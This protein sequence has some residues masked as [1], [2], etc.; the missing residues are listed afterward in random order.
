MSCFEP[1]GIPAL[2]RFCG[3]MTEFVWY[4]LCPADFDHLR[5]TFNLPDY[6][7]IAEYVALVGCAPM[8]R[9]NIACSSPSTDNPV[10]LIVDDDVACAT[11]LRAGLMKVHK[12]DVRTAASG[13]D[14]LCLAREAWFDLLLVDLRLPDMSGLDLVRALMEHRGGVPFVLVSGFADVPTTVEAMRLGAFSVIEKPVTFDDLAKVVHSAVFPPGG[15][16]LTTAFHGNSEMPVMRRLARH[17][18]AACRSDEDLNTLAKWARFE[19]VSYSTLCETCR[20]AGVRPHDARDFA[21]M[22]RAVARANAEQCPVRVLLQVGD[23][24][25]LSVLLRRSGL[26]ETANEP[27]SVQ[28]F[29]QTQQFIGTDTS[30]VRAVLSFLSNQP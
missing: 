3:P 14:A 2:G 26:T 19:G 23:R 25:T 29:L 20:L 30:L 13:G 8:D 12:F 24:R 17:M 18:V 22:L 4:P 27:P 15:R 9:E 21:R 28:R 6:L 7:D 1:D 10:V 5:I 16:R 11:L